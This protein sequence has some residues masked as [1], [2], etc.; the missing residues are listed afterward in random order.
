MTEIEMDFKSEFNDKGI[1]NMS[2]ER[3]KQIL[4]ELMLAIEGHA[5][6]RAP[7]DSGRLRASIHTYPKTPASVITVSD[8]V[9]YGNYQE[10]GTMK[11]KAQP[12]M[13]PAKDIALKSDLPRIIKKYETK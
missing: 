7:V 2:D 4:L 11:M 6:R 10:F 13:R 9:K 8:G 5:K 3:L 12:F 1:E